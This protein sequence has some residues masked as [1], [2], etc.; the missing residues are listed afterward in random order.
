MHERLIFRII[1]NISYQGLCIT[2]MLT[3]FAG[4]EGW[5]RVQVNQLTTVHFLYNAV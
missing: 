5:L 3:E 4:Y 1:F 2:E